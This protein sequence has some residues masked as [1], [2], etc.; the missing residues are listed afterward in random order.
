MVGVGGKKK[1][2]LVNQ[3]PAFYFY[4]SMLVVPMFKKKPMIRIVN[5][6]QFQIIQDKKPQI[7]ASCS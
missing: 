1:L 4:I 2:A 7:I 3:F 5:N 6:K